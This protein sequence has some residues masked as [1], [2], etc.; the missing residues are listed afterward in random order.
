MEPAAS[1]FKSSI[2]NPF[3][4]SLVLISLVIIAFWDGVVGGIPR[5]DQLFYLHNIGGINDLKDIMTTAPA[6]NRT[7]SGDY[8]LYRPVLYLLMGFCYYF[9][10][11]NFVLW[12]TASLTLHILVVLSLFFLLRRV[13]LFKKT[14]WPFAIALLFA[15]SEM[16]SEMVLW[17]HIMGYLLASLLAVLQTLFYVR[18]LSEGRTRYAAWSLGFG[19][20]AEFTYESFLALNMI[21]AGIL[22]FS[23]FQP[24]LKG[25]QWIPRPKPEPPTCLKVALLFF[26]ISLFLP[27]VSSMDSYLRAGALGSLEKPLDFNGIFMAIG[28]TFKQIS[29]W[30]RALL[31]PLGIQIVPGIHAYY[32]GTEYEFNFLHILNFLVVPAI[33]VSGGYLFWKQNKLTRLQLAMIFLPGLI[34]LI[35][36]SYII[37]LG[38]AVPRG[39]EYVLYGNLNYS[40]IAQLIFILALCLALF[41][42]RV[43]P[44]SPAIAPPSFDFQRFTQRC[45]LIGVMVLAILN[46]KETMELSNNFRVKFAPQKKLLSTLAQ[47]HQET[48]PVPRK[49]F[50]VSPNCQND[51]FPDFEAHFRKGSNWKGPATL[52]DIL[53]PTTSFS[54]NQSKIESR[55]AQVETISC[56]KSILKP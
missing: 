33:L 10:G 32:A 14:S 42:I 43:K 41:A 38:R 21:F 19:L 24:R 22:I 20:T 11:Y 34:F 54:L 8:I 26:L 13:P 52:A 28:F 1:H 25:L 18:F 46:F 31:L 47:W 49:Y 51:V 29:R 50:I 56:E 48:P 3:F 37:A 30:L 45:F 53:Y 9:F 4:Q 44:P 2:H 39:I 27:V 55:E 35:A 16:G 23:T 6:F 15:V 36:Y 12:Q 40:Y 5:A 7:H 17:H